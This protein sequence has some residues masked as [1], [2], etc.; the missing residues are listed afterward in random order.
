M[1]DLSKHELAYALLR[2]LIQL[3]T[4]PIGFKWGDHRTES[5]RDEGRRISSQILSLVPDMG[6]LAGLAVRLWIAQQPAILREDYLHY[7][8]PDIFRGNEHYCAYP[9]DSGVDPDDEDAPVI[10]WADRAG[11]TSLEDA[12][13]D[14]ALLC[15]QRHREQYKAR[16]R[17]AAADRRRERLLAKRAEDQAASRRQATIQQMMTAA[18]APSS[19]ARH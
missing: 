14:K 4:A 17:E 8:G 2:S 12:F 10:T 18:T 6:D 19:D 11:L 5:D 9:D 3:D 1:T 13:H 7:H 16:K 15:L